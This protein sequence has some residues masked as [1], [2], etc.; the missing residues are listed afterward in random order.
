MKWSAA[1]LESRR[2]LTRLHVSN[3]ITPAT[4]KAAAKTMGNVAALLER[5][6]AHG[7]LRRAPMDFV[8]ALMHSLADT[9]MDFMIHDPAHAKKHCKA[10]FDAL[11]RVIA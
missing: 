3:E 9:T 2:A 11:W 1:S 4:R 7:P 5:S 10:G 6:R 8:V